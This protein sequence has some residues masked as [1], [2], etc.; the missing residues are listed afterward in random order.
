MVWAVTAIT[1]L[2]TVTVLAALLYALAPGGIGIA[3]RLSRLIQ[4]PPQ[5]VRETTF[6]DKQKERVRDSLAAVGSL[7]SPGPA[8]P[9]SKAQLPMVRA[10]YRSDS[11]MMAMHGIKILMPVAFVVLVFTTG[12]YRLNVVFVPLLA[13]VVGYLLPELWLMWRVQARQHRLRLGLPDALDMLVICVEAG[14]GLDQALMRVAQELRITHPQLS[15]ELQLVNME[16]RVGKTR[17]EAMRELARRTGVEDIK[18]LVAML[19]QTERFGTS[20]AQSLRVHSDDL[21]MK[22]RQRAEEMSAKTTVKM[23]P[24]L[25]FF[26]F[27]ALMVVILGPAVITL[28]RQFLPALNK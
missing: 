14:L 22:R 24:P 10:G 1:F 28:M 15:D 2:A 25:V 12:M 26:I 16:M 18:A 11:A 20:I 5:Q 17:L 7:V 21:R 3:E 6:A 27:P 19:I 8:L 13:A 23:V 4:P 9:G